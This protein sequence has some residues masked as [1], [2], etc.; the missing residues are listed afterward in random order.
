MQKFHLPEKAFRPTRRIKES[1][2]RRTPIMK[3]RHKKA[4][5]LAHFRQKRK[6]QTKNNKNRYCAF[7]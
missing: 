2:A 7:F 6:E 3:K 4:P 5:I 1:V